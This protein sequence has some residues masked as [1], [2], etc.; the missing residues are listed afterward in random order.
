MEMCYDGALVMPS[1]YAV[2]DEDEMMYVEGGSL[3]TLKKNLRGIST[4]VKGYLGKWMSGATVGQVMKSCGLTWSQIATMAGSYSP[5]CAK[6][7]AAISAVTRWLG[8]HA[9]IIGCAVGVAGFAL[10]WNVNVF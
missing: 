1:N 4:L 10:L 9:F 6:V 3:A 5:L 8:A 7:V 2:M